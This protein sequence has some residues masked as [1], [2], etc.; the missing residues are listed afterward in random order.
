MSDGFSIELSQQAA[1][2][3][4]RLSPQQQDRITEKLKEASV[5]PVEVSKRLV[6]RCGHRRLRVGDLRILFEIDT[7]RRKLMVTAI[8]PRGDAYKHSKK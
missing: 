6:N 8:L 2:Y 4:K 1:S 3:L 5:N 7:E